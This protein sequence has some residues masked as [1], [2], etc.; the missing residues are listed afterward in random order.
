MEVLVNVV[1]QEP[2]M[3]EQHVAVVVEN[4]QCVME[5]VEHILNVPSVK[6]MDVQNVTIRD[7]PNAQVVMGLVNVIIA[8][9]RANVLD[10]TE[11]V[12]NK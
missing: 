3:R 12:K 9:V 7:I 6:V 8:E 5:M 2:W 11:Q 10:V 1:N 4:V